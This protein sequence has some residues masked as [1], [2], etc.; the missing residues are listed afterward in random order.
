MKAKLFK[1]LIAA[2]PDDAEIMLETKPDAEWQPL[3]SVQ[4]GESPEDEDTDTVAAVAGGLAGIYYGCDGESG[5]PDEW[6]AQIPRRDWIKGLCA[7]LIF[8]N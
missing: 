8:E 5:V 4:I 3:K 1:K 6:I 7:E 2:L